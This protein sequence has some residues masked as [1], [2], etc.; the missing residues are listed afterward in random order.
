MNRPGPVLQQDV[1]AAASDVSQVEPATFQEVLDG[2]TADTRH[3]L[4]GH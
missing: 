1:A 2:Q 3:G 4:I